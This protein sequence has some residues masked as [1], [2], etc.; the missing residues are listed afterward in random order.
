MK[1]N[2]RIQNLG[3]IFFTLI[4][5]GLPLEKIQA[6]ELLKITP[7]V[8]N[9]PSSSK[10]KIIFSPGGFKV[11][12]KTQKIKRL[13]SP[14]NNV[15]LMWATEVLP[16]TNGGYINC[17]LDPSTGKP[18]LRNQAIGMGHEYEDYDKTYIKTFSLG[19]GPAGYL[20]ARKD[21]KNEN[22]PE[23]DVYKSIGKS[24]IYSTSYDARS[25]TA[26]IRWMLNSAFLPSELKI[27]VAAGGTHTD[28]GFDHKKGTS[29]LLFSN[30]SSLTTEALKVEA[31]LQFIDLF[32]AHSGFTQSN[33]WVGLLQK[34]NDGVFYPLGIQI[35]LLDSRS[36]LNLNPIINSAYFSTT[37][38]APLGVTVLGDNTFFLTNQKQ[39]DYR[40]VSFKMTKQ[41]ILDVI[42]R[43]NAKISDN[44]LKFLTDLNFVKFQG[45]KI[46]N[47][48]GAL[49]AG[50]NPYDPNWLVKFQ[51]N[52][53]SLLVTQDD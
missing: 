12:P 5:M 41:N 31:E 15:W 7:D 1:I 14:R 17:N 32:V 25:G 27:P 36:T 3:L 10:S 19:V 11:D 50:N 9:D 38:D 37:L 23:T 51:V 21:F 48:S 22:L 6:R 33:L 16:A 43:V 46:G 20:R 8:F 18:P 28:V 30:T 4:Q 26:T 49:L 47:E 42:N 53:K 35:R 13:C 2:T 24:Y 45:A 40:K 52:I 34:R 29:P 39:A 44:N